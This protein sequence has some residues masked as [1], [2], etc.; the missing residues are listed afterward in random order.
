MWVFFYLVFKS[1]AQGEEGHAMLLSQPV[2]EDVDYVQ[3][4]KPTWEG[5]TSELYPN[6]LCHKGLCQIQVFLA[7]YLT[8]AEGY[9][10][11]VSSGAS[12]TPLLI[13][14]H[15]RKFIL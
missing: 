5:R 15:R 9:F 4:P 14:L 7:D 11:A 12:L 13:P 1:G 3:P 6:C 8:P 2:H 10:L